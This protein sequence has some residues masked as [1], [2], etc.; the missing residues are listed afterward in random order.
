MGDEALLGKICMLVHRG[1][2]NLPGSL[3]CPCDPPPAAVLGVAP[4]A[5][6][7]SGMRRF[8]ARPVAAPASS[9]FL[10]GSL[11]RLGA[12]NSCLGGLLACLWAGN[13]WRSRRAMA[14]LL[15]TAVGA[16]KA[17]T[18]CLMGTPGFPDMP[19]SSSIKAGR[20]EA[21][22]VP[23]ALHSMLRPEADRQSQQLCSTPQKAWKQSTA[24]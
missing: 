11:A 17:M 6:P 15:G 10:G 7:P 13:S 8:E 5:V 14:L 1:H 22:M 12:G 4:F 21:S 9:K 3:S 18:W 2:A 19:V 24:G 23:H 16:L 20:P